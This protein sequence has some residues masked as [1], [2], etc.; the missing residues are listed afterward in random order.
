MIKIT[1]PVNLAQL[2]REYNGQG[3]NATLDDNGAIIEIALADN[4]SGNEAELKVILD[5]HVA[6]DEQA[7]KASDKAALLSKLG[8]TEDE[9]KLLLS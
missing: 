5:K 7:Q 1:K 3:L 8:I 6:I 9:A 2:D 4:N